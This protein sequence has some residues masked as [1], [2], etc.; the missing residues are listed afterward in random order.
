MIADT[1]LSKISLSLPP[2][3]TAIAQ[4]PSLGYIRQQVNVS[5]TE[6]KLERS[7]IW[8]DFGIGYFSQ[9]IIG[10]QDVNG[11]PRTF[12][13]GD[14]FTG[15]QAGISI[16]LWFVPYTSK[17]KAARINEDIARTDAENFARS[18]SGNYFSLIEEYRKFSG[19]VDYYELQALPEAGLIIEQATRSYKAGAMD[20]LDYVLSLSRALTIRQNYLDALNSYNQTVISIEYITGKTF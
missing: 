8:P 4:N 14:R 3:S 6:R 15:I 16:P 10:T 2:D 7:R 13:S 5:G 1:V 20:Y 12:G 18:L 17:T 19:T 9:S 11:I